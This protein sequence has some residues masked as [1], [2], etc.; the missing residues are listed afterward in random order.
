MTAAPY[1]GRMPKPPGADPATEPQ[2][3][4]ASDTQLTSFVVRF[5]HAAAPAAAPARAWHGLIRHVQS[6]AERYFTRWDEA[7]AFIAGYVRVDD[8]PDR[9]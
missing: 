3:Q 8:G 1:S 9:L 7:V 5:V 6:D 2:P 4:P